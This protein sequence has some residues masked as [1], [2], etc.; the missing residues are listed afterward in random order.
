MRQMDEESKRLMQALM[1]KISAAIF[2]DGL[3]VD[4]AVNVLLNVVVYTLMQTDEPEDIAQVLIENIPAAIAH[5]RKLKQS[6]EH[7]TAADQ[8]TQH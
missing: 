4:S 8:D 6:V 1:E 7:A 5:A 2:E 3:S